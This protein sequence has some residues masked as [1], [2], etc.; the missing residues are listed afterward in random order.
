MVLPAGTELQVVVRGVVSKTMWR[1]SRQDLRSVKFGQP[2][3]IAAGRYSGLHV[4]H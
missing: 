1:R 2:L 3:G 4:S